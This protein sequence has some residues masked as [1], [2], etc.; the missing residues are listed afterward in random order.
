MIEKTLDKSHWKI[1]ISSLEPKFCFQICPVWVVL[2][3]SHTHGWRLWSR[4]FRT[5]AKWVT[6]TTSSLKDKSAPGGW[7]QTGNDGWAGEAMAGEATCRASLPGL[8]I[9]GHTITR[10]NFW[11]PLAKVSLWSPRHSQRRSGSTWKVLLSPPEIQSSLFNELRAPLLIHASRGQRRNRA[12]MARSWRKDHLLLSAGP[13][14][15]G[16]I[17]ALSGTTCNWYR[18]VC[19]GPTSHGHHG[20]KATAGHPGEQKR[21]RLNPPPC[22]DFSLQ[23]HQ[24]ERGSAAGLSWV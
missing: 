18:G 13:C 23:N 14:T 24:P 1:P 17:I 11:K 3:G 4:C 7:R 5:S 20:A 12:R 8:R 9:R 6:W 16:R 22:S 19:L 2:N 21:T 10:T 15:S